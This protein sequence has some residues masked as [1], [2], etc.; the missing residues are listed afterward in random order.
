M[1]KKEHKDGQCSTDN[2]DII[3]CTR[4]I[5]GQIIQFKLNNPSTSDVYKLYMK[6]VGVE[7]NVESDS[8]I[9][10]ATSGSLGE[11]VKED[12]KGLLYD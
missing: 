2:N 11:T 12:I 10:L 9:E 8:S 4:T 6:S 3:T 1:Y 7:D 5:H